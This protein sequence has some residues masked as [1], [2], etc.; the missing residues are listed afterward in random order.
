MPNTN[1]GAVVFVENTATRAFD[2]G[3]DV[4]RICDVEVSTEAI[5][6]PRVL[7]VELND[8][9]AAESRT[10]DLAVTEELMHNRRTNID[11]ALVVRTLQTRCETEA[12]G[13]AVQTVDLVAS[14]TKREAI[15]VEISIGNLGLWFDIEEAVE[16]K[17]PTSFG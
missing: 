11:V 13:Q 9:G 17:A 2:I 4:G 7:A 12:G 16:I 5:F 1:S 15:T 6:N 8:A 3:P 10:S 14:L